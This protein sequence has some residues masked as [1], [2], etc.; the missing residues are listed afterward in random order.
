MNDP[1]AAVIA[2]SPRPTTHREEAAFNDLPI[3]ALVETDRYCDQ[4]SH[5]L[6]SQAIRRDERTGVLLVRCPE[7]GRLH[8]A[9]GTATAVRPWLHRFAVILLL[10][11]FATIGFAVTMVGMAQVGLTIAIMEELTTSTRIVNIT[12]TSTTVVRTQHR[13]PVAQTRDHFWMV[14]ST[15]VLLGAVGFIA[16]TASVIAFHHWRR[17]AQLILATGPPIVVA[18][19]LWIGFA[20][21]QPG[22]MAWSIRPIAG[23]AAAL[24]VGGLIAVLVGRMVARF[25][26]IALVPPRMRWPLA[27]L[28]IADGKTLS[29][30]AA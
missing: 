13:T 1:D 26:V 17:W 3:L 11:W 16:M 22:L 2:P 28:W 8:P 12:G 10:L 9:A 14:L 18:S 25:M 23:S 24:I 30:M 29:G 19:L 4:C 21:D 15:R 7:C 20:Y 27:F 6:L 5:N